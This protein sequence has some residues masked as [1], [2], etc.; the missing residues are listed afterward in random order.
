[1]PQQDNVNLDFSTLLKSLSF[2]YQSLG[3]VKSITEGLSKFDI[4]FKDTNS[5]IRVNPNKIV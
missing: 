1:M 3:N 5:Y 4:H 2:L